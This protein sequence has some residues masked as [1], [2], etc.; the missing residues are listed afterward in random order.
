MVFRS[1]EW[2]LRSLCKTSKRDGITIVAVK[3]ENLE[4]VETAL[5]LIRD[6]DPLRYKRLCKD[7]NR[8]N[9]R[10]LA[11]SIGRFVPQT[12]TCELELRYLEREDITH[13]L[14]AALIVH[15]ASHARLHQVG[16]R[17]PEPLRERIE[18]FCVRQEFLFGKKLERGGVVCAS[19]RRYLESPPPDFSNSAMQERVGRGLAELF[20]YAGLSENWANRLLNFL[21]WL[22]RRKRNK[23]PQA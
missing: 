23:I 14:I 3:Q 18:D 22:T 20:Q 11:G 4:R 8:I 15:E 13:E 2:A 19:A 12:K 16:I 21:R 10:L 17:Y 9:V 6:F 5:A 1:N 7:L